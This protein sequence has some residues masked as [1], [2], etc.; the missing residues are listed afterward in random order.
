MSDLDGRLFIRRPQGFVP[1]AKSCDVC[2]AAFAMGKD[3]GPKRFASRRLCSSGCAYVGRNPARWNTP[4]S[5]YA[6]AIPEPNSGCWLWTGPVNG[7]GYGKVFYHGKQYKTHRLS[8]KLHCGLA[9][10]DHALHRCDTP[11]CINPEHLFAGTHQDNMA[12][13]KRKGR[14]LGKGGRR[15]D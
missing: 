8:L 12:D 14:R 11:S 2:G 6:Q 3:E 13:M 15:D 5:F 9:K 1:A 4:E 7:D 10:G